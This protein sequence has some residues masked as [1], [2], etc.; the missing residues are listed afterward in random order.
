MIF[1]LLL[2]SAYFYEVSESHDLG[3]PSFQSLLSPACSLS[4]H[5]L[6]TYLSD[7]LTNRLLLLDFPEDTGHPSFIMGLS[8][9]LCKRHL[10]V[11]V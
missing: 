9:H 1:S 4:K 3:P 11:S 10:R 8:F 6:P 7:V 2:E 5:L